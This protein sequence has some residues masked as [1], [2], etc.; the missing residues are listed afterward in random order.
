M[1]VGGAL[2]LGIFL[3]S[4]LT[5]SFGGDVLT[6]SNILNDT[7]G[8]VTFIILVTLTVMGAIGVAT[9]YGGNKQEI[10]DG[11]TMASKL[12]NV[13]AIMFLIVATLELV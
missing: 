5:S 11:N 8:L 12:M 9:F 4:T 13:V 1:F 3:L 6:F 10:F 2:G 7:S